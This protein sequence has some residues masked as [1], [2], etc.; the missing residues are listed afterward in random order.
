MTN[1][2]R[3]DSVFVSTHSIRSGLR[4]FPVT[5]EFLAGA[6]HYNAT[7]CID[8]RMSDFASEKADNHYWYNLYS[9]IT[10]HPDYAERALDAFGW[11]GCGRTWDGLGEKTEYLLCLDRLR[12]SRNEIIISLILDALEGR[13]I[14][15]VS[16]NFAEEIGAHNLRTFDDILRW[17]DDYAESSS[18]DCRL[19]PTES[20][21]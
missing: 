8:D 20:P 16:K 15:E 11:D 13:G 19:F 5:S 9:S 14:R 18:R 3:Y 1:T 10:D 7:D 6:E 2:E 21:M 12:E 17:A 4:L